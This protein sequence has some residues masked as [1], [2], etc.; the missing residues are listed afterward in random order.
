MTEAKVELGRYLFYDTR[1]SGNNTMSCASCHHQERAFTDGLA[2]P[3]GSTGESHVRNAQTLT[4][5]AYNATFTWGSPVLTEI[6][7]QVV[8]PLFGEF[9]VEMGITGSEDEVLARLS[10]A[11]LYR[12]L[13]AT[14]YPDEAE[15]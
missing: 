4:N 11:E 10:E 7:Q 5:V 9:P 1:L 3:V 6:E 12:V 15:P 14:A 8:I 2:V 13:F